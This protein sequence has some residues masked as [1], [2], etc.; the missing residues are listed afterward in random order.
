MQTL[1]TYIHFPENID[2]HLDTVEKGEKL[3]KDFQISIDLAD[4][5]KDTILYYSPSNTSAFF[6][7]LGAYEELNKQNIGL[8]SFETTIGLVFKDNQVV[9]IDEENILDCKIATYNSIP[10]NLDQKP[11][12]TFYDLAKRHKTLSINDKQIILNLFDGYSSYENPIVVLITCKGNTETIK[13]PFVT[14]FREL[15]EWLQKNRLKRNF[16]KTDKRHIEYSG[17]HRKEKSGEYKSPLLGGLG[18]RENA[19]SFLKAAIGD[20]YSASNKKDLINYD[21]NKQEYIWYEYENDNPQNQYHA[22][23]LVKAFSH[24]RDTATISNISQRVIKILEYRADN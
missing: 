12:I 8:Y 13:V 16:N 20:K 15:D 9:P 24:E 7:N 2:E 1:H 5:D 19:E 23:H 21:T 3:L 4:C 22:Y 17:D 10:E 14:N 18:G 6:S 11:P